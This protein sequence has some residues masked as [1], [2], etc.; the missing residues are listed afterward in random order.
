MPEQREIVWRQAPPGAALPARP[1][2]ADEARSRLQAGNADFAKIGDQGGRQVIHVG[3][4]AFGLPPQDGAGL[5][6][7]PFAAVLACSDA[8]APVELLFNQAGN[9]IFVVRVA[10]NVPGRE[11]LG[12][13]NYAVT[14]LPTVQMITVLGHTSCGAVSAA[15][16]ALLSPQVYLDVVQ[17]PS[18]RAIVDALLAGVR[19]ADQALV[20]T[21][22][23]DIRQAAGFREALIDLAVT[24]NAAITAVVLA[25]AVDCA[26]TYGVFNLNNRTVGVTG[27]QG[28]QAGLHDPPTGDRSLTEVLRWGAG[29]AAL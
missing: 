28:W 6:Q 24:A 29:H 15:V 10:G 7:Q 22:G 12:S 27:S 13:L 11:C 16:D 25:R 3:P 26:V 23:R 14:N 2:T 21:Y 8:R 19:M 18:L 5:A 1:R 20:D 4:E 9:S 17:D